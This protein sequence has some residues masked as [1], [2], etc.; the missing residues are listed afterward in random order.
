MKCPY[1]T[2]NVTMYIASNVNLCYGG[3]MSE[4]RGILP[5]SDL[6]YTYR[7]PGRVVL[8]HFYK[9]NKSTLHEQ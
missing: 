3:Q 1:V 9:R 2:R 8:F 5:F 6:T 7:A 4:Q